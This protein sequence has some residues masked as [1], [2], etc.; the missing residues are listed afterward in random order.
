M[1]L[2]LADKIEEKLPYVQAPTLVVRGGNDPLVPQL[3]EFLAHTEG[4]YHVQ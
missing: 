3:A 2:V 4:R 1:Q